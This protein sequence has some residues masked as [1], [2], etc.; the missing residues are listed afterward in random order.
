M[1]IDVQKALESRSYN[2]T[3]TLVFKINDAFCSWNDGVFELEIQS[4]GVHCSVSTKSPDLVV[5]VSDFASTYLGT[6]GFSKLKNSGRLKEHTQGSVK[7]A[8][9]M[10][11]C[12]LSPWCPYTF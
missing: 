3:G 5:D 10:F 8:D 6:I 9:Q 1:L 12:E 11:N 4:G 2:V 7:L